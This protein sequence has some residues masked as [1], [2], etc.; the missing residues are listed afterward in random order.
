MFINNLT[1]IIKTNTLENNYYICDIDRAKKL[2]LSGFS[3]IS[4]TEDNY[5]IFYKSAVLMEF[6]QKG[7]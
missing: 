1:E 5:F 3:P 6:L 7:E 2:S 4:V